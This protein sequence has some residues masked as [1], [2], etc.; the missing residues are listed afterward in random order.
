M[1]DRLDSGDSEHNKVGQ[2]WV[3]IYRHVILSSSM[4]KGW[5]R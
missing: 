5:L 1:I 2:H 4:K 3:V